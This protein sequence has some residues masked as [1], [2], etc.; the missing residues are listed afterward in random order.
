MKVGLNG[1]G[2]SDPNGDLLSYQWTQ[3]GGPSV[4]L[5]SATSARP[6]F[7]APDAAAT[8]TFQLVVNDGQ[9][10]SAPSSVTI[11]VSERRGGGRGPDRH[12]YGLLANQ[13]PARDER[14]RRHHQRLSE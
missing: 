4:T 10:N 2:S 8:L 9:V 6:T 13:R 5:S 7:T 11:T 1:S 3:T 14:H 12:R